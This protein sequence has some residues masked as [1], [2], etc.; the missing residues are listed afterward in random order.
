MFGRV[1][2]HTN[3]KDIR[4][5]KGR[6]FVGQTRSA[7]KTRNVD[8]R[9]LRRPEAESS[10]LGWRGVPAAIGPRSGAFAA[11]SVFRAAILLVETVSVARAELQASY[12]ERVVLPIAHVVSGVRFVRPG[13]RAARAELLLVV[14]L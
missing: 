12:I 13:A 9:S 11:L 4:T 8:W 3:K 2:I 14:K 7:T 10:L 1:R 6:V 5:R